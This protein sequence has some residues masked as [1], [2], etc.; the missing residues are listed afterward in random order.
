MVGYLLVGLYLPLADSFR[1]A[2]VAGPEAEQAEDDLADVLHDLCPVPGY[3]LANRAELQGCRRESAPCRQC[4]NSCVYYRSGGRD[5]AVGRLLH[6][7]AAS[8][9]VDQRERSAR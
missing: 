3:V 4:W 6:D 8:A 7:A 9:S 5:L 1:S 2:A